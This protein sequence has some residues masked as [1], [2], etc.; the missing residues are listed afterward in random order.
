MENIAKKL[1][2]LS[3][4]ISALKADGEPKLI[5]VTKNRTPET[6]LSCYKLGLRDFGENRI[7]EAMKKIEHLPRD[8]NWHFIGHLQS[9]KAKDVVGKFVLIHSVDSLKLLEK[10]DG[11]AK[12]LGIT[13]DVLLEVNVSG[14]K[15]KYGFKQSEVSGVMRKAKAL[16]NTKVIGLMTMAPYGATT[17]GLHLIFGSLRRLSDELGLEELSM[18]MSDDFEVAIEEGATILRIGRAIFQ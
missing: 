12:E 15:S 7:Q 10:I 18:G 9:N 16:D 2:Y 6:I 11:K 3:S 13:Q 4:R 17:E 5:V 1:E 8:I 14:E